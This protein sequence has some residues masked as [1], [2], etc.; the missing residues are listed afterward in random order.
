MISLAGGA[1]NPNTFPFQ[2][3]S[4]QVK[5]GDT[6][7]FNETMMKRALQYL[8]SSG[9]TFT[10]FLQPTT[11]Q[12]RVKWI[13]V[14]QEGFCKLQPLGC[15]LINVPSDQHGMIPGG[16][17]EVLSRWD[18]ADV[19]KPHSPA[20]RVLYTIPNGGNPTRASMTTQRKR[21]IYELARQYDLLIN[22][23]DPYYFLQFLSMDVDRQIIRTDSFSK[24]VS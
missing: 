1:P 12:R 13:C 19:H 18:P 9:R 17:K 20:P 3:C 11:V 4:I 22:E 2:S 23:D 6:L 15:N 14:L 5:N 7:I 10:T 8:A 24:I 21:E 16:L